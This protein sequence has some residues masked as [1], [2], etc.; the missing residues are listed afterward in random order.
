[1]R[2]SIQEST[3]ILGVFNT[4]D[5]VTIDIYDLDTDTKVVDGAPCSE[6]A[7][8]GVFKYEFTQAITEKKE[9]LWIMT[10]GTTNKYGKIVLGGWLD[11][12]KTKIKRGYGILNRETMHKIGSTIKMRF[13]SKSGNTVKIYVYKPD[14]T[15]VVSGESMTEIGTTGIYYYDLTFD[16]A[17][18]TGDFLIKC[19]DEDEGI[20]DGITITVL[21][22]DDWFATHSEV[23]EMENEIVKELEEKNLSLDLGSGSIILRL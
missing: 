23:E 10:N 17:W 8:T 9:Y 12:V 19:K 5:T 22:E 21:S 15:E 6:I 18:G 14:G 7:S 11:E 16:T 2:Y 20:E 1:V 3:Y 4:G 13:K